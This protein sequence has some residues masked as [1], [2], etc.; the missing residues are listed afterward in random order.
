ML[1]AVDCVLLP[2]LRER[3]ANNEKDGNNVGHYYINGAPYTIKQRFGRCITF[4]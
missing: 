3:E 2:S 4:C 1:S